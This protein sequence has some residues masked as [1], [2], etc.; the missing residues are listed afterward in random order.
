MQEETAGNADPET[1]RM[2]SQVEFC[3]CSPGSRVFPSAAVHGDS[4]YIFGGHDGASYRNELLVFNLETRLWLPET[5]F[6]GE[7]PSPRDAHAAVVHKGA[8]YVFG[9]YDSKRYLNDF[10]RFHFETEKWTTVSFSGVT[11]SPRGGHTAVVHADTMLVF[12]GCDGWNYFNDCYSFNFDSSAWAPVRVTGTAPGARSAPATVVHEQQGAMYV[13]GGYDGARSLN[14]LFRFDIA[15]SEWS[16]VRVTGTPPSPRGGHTAAVCGDTMYVFGG[17]SGRSPFNDLC[18]FNFE[19]LVWDKLQL[20][21]SAPAARCAHVCVT[22]GNALFVFGGYDGRQYFDDAFA[23]AFD[24][25]PDSPSHVLSGDLES[26]VNNPQFSDVSFSVEGQVVYAHKFILFARS[27]YFRSMFTGGYRESTDACITIPSVTHSVFLSVLGYLYT[28]KLDIA[29][30]M[31]V[32]ILAV[33]NLY[34][35]EPL[36]KVCADLLAKG[37]NSQNVACILQAADT[38]QTAGLRVTCL[39]FM[40]ANFA[41]VVR[42]DA[43]KELVKTETRGLVVQFLKEASTRLVPAPPV[44]RRCNEAAMPDMDRCNLDG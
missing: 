23:F 28:G 4:L 39:N 9:G 36:K 30:E 24:D 16:Q 32:D 12:G 17:K 35:I 1:S 44:R 33:A 10:H 5:L 37:L 19:K 26:M 6:N 11:P 31:A 27:E 34:N 14:D 40:V 3:S 15:A 13:F 20:G 41:Q 8:M 43:F 18:S 22:Y 2:W 25:P 21:G 38:Y 29:P 42:S 7:H